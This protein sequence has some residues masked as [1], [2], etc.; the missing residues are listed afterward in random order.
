MK[1]LKILLSIILATLFCVSIT[2]CKNSS[3]DSFGND[4]PVSETLL[5]L[6]M[7]TL[8]I[9]LGGSAT[10]KAT[11]TGSADRVVW[12]I[13]DEG[14]ATIDDGTYECR[15]YGVAEGSTILTATLGDIIQTCTVNVTGDKKAELIPVPVLQFDLTVETVSV[16]YSFKPL[17]SLMLA[18]ETVQT[19]ILLASSDTDVVKIENGNIVALSTGE[20]VITAT[21]TYGGEIYQH[22]EK[23]T[24]VN[25]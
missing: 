15:V 8:D 3:S 24:V 1:R 25:E 2:A 16:G 6:N 23:L 22:S 21:C 13:A 4:D 9:P 14:V 5:S 19:E 17:A 11:Q 10:V 7:H 20:T 12:T 18:G